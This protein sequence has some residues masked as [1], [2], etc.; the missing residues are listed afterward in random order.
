MTEWLRR[1]SWPLPWWYLPTPTVGVLVLVLAGTW[2]SLSWPYQEWQY[3]NAQFHQQTAWVAPLCAAVAAVVAGRLTAPGRVF[4]LPVGSRVGAPAVRRHLGQLGVALVGGYLLGL[5][6][7]V[8]VTVVDARFGGP[9][10]LVMASGLLGL[11]AAIAVGYLIGVL[12][13]TALVAPVAFLLFFGLAAL[14]SGG[15]T[16]A[17]VI[18]VLH[19][20]PALG[21]VENTAMVVFRCDFFLLVT[22]AASGIAAQLL[23]N[24]A[25][26]A[27][28]GVA[29]AA[30]FA[31]VPVTLGSL[32]VSTTPDLFATP[33]AAPRECIEH[34]RIEYC[35]HQGHGSELDALV[36]ALGPVF[37][38]RGPQEQIRRVHDRALLF[39][40]RHMPNTHAAIL[41][42]GDSLNDAASRGNEARA[43]AAELAG[44]SACVERYPRRGYA[45]SGGDHPYDRA[46]DLASW[47]AHGGRAVDDKNVFG[48]VATGVMREWMA[49]HPEEIR[50]CSL[51]TVELP[52]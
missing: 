22:A 52:S 35:V 28:S 40:S 19:I 32:G 39:G 25:A 18:P 12:A 23:A 16:Y 11:M 27:R 6:P 4:A 7:L 45:T 5:V 10:V 33:P 43:L 2:E 26:R 41:A 42:P 37:T 48:K 51:D 21:Q 50:T 20:D 38:A 14:G 34:N 3:T 36:A 8:V 9:N 47:L 13:R 44:M 24:R 29:V 46:S 49:E 30:A 1:L 31:V 17:A 15:D